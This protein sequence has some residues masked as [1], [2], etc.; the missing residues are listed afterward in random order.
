MADQPTVELPDI[1]DVSPEAV[2]STEA[3]LDPQVKPPAD[4]RVDV[5]KKTGVERKRWAMSLSIERAERSS[6]STGLVCFYV[7]A[8]VR[9]SGIPGDK[10]VG[11]YVFSRYFVN[12]PILN[13]TIT[14]P[15]SHVFMNE[16]SMK[17]IVSLLKAA[18]LA[19]ENMATEGLK[20]SYLAHI[21]PKDTDVNQS[22]LLGNLFVGNC[23]EQPNNSPKAKYPRETSVELW[24]P[25][26]TLPDTE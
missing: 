10:N 8:R 20:A 7:Q 11:K 23:V 9:P 12:F 1:I 15:A 16:R 22:P 19:P 24:L 21:F 6:T 18:N 2:S 5:D 14:E 25:A 26:P 4:A 3:A 17:S 13:G